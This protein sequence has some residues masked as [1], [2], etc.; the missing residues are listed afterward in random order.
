MFH[1]SIFQRVFLGIIPGGL[2]SVAQSLTAGGP[3]RVVTDGECGPPG[4]MHRAY[5]S[6]SLELSCVSCRSHLGKCFILLA[7]AHVSY[8]FGRPPLLE[9]QC[10]PWGVYSYIAFWCAL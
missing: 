2:L 1:S 10:G 7:L 4:W 8:S 6:R 9:C 3:V 5:L